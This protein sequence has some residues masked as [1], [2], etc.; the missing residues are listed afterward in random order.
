[1]RSALKTT[2]FGKTNVYRQQVIQGFLESADRLFL[3]RILKRKLE[4]QSAYTC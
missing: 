1:M 4:M 2:H 3:G